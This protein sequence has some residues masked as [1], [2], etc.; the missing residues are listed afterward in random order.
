MPTAQEYKIVVQ[1]P[2]GIAFDLGDSTYSIER[3]ALDA[4]GAEI[5]EIDASSEDEFIAGARDADAVIARYRFISEHIIA[6][7]D[8]AIVI[9]VGG[10]GADLV[11]VAAATAHDIVV[12]NVPDVFIEEVADHGMALLLGVHRRLR[13]MQKLTNEGRW[14]EGRPDYV[15]VPRLWG[16][17]L[18][19]ISF[20]NVATAMARRAKAF[21]LHVSAYDPY[22]S[23]L[24][25]TGEGVE[26]ASS[27]SELLARS[28]FVSQHAPWTV[29]TEKM[30]AAEQFAAMKPGAIFINV[31]RGKTVDEPA[32]IAA[33]Q[34]NEI[35]GAGLDVFYEEP[36]DPGNPLLHM[37]NVMSTP[38]VASATARMMP[39]TR[40]RLGRELALVLQ[41]RWP[42]NAVNPDV[43]SRV[44]LTRWQPLHYDRG[45]GG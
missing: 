17:N 39:E 41:G 43:L 5:V 6:N 34:N 11:D 27:L 29:E 21:G 22:V 37:D 24:N 20:G 36:V 35:A 33:L 32:L 13:L 10:V 3:E 28:D 12:T 9:G 26:P 8:K 38:H 45:P 25:M 42:R 19:L 44:K 18:G 7:L 15:D 30:L 2:S 16:R 14:Q 4:I 40:R 1:K 31:G 23:E